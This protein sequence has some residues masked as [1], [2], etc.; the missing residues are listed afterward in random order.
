VKSERVMMSLGILTTLRR[1]R[2]DERG[3]FTAMMAVLFPVL[4]GIGAL[5]VETGIWYTVKRHDQS[6]ADVAA[7]A[8]AMEIAR[9]GTCTSGTGAGAYTSCPAAAIAAKVNGVDYNDAAN[10]A[11]TITS[12]YTGASCPA[13][14]SC[15]EAIIRHQQIPVLASLF[16]G[17]FTIAN[18]AV[19]Q[20]K[21]NDDKT[22]LLARTTTG[23]A[24]I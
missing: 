9:D 13:G 6:I 5:G 18:R 19:A 1:L 12:P 11:S 24:W 21:I 7:V 14:E 10:S 22:S 8:G 15:V 20:V 16:I 23:P 4:I 3:A 2:R 17:N